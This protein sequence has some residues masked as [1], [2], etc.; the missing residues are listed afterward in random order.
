MILRGLTSTDTFTKK[1]SLYLLKR[2]I[3]VSINNPSIQPTTGWTKYFQI[4]ESNQK[5]MQSQWDTYLM[6]LET[7]AEFAVHLI[8]PIFTKITEL[9]PPK[10]IEPDQIKH[11]Y[12]YH[13]WLE[14]LLLQS[15]S[16]VNLG[17]ARMCLAAFY[18]FD[19]EKY[20]IFFSH[21]F[22]CSEIF[23]YFAGVKMYYKK[24]KMGDR[25]LKFYPDYLNRLDRE[26]AHSAVRALLTKLCTKQSRATICYIL[27]CLTLVRFDFGDEIIKCLDALYETHVVTMV[28]WLRQHV[29]RLIVHAMLS[30][31]DYKNCTSDAVWRFLSKFNKWCL[32]SHSFDLICNWLSC[33][34]SRMIHDLKMLMEEIYSN[35]EI[36]LMLCKRFTFMVPYLNASRDDLNDMLTLFH[37]NVKSIYTYVLFALLFTLYLATHFDVQD[38]EEILNFLK[39]TLRFDHESIAE[40]WHGLKPDY[41]KICADYIEKVVACLDGLRL[42]LITFLESLKSSP[43]S[44]I[45]AMN[46][47]VAVRACFELLNAISQNVSRWNSDQILE[48]LQAVTNTSIIRVATDSR[49]STISDQDSSQHYRALYIAQWKTAR[50]LLSQ[51]DQN[52]YDPIAML[53]SCLDALDAITLEDIN[54]VMD[55][56]KIVLPNVIRVDHD[57]DLQKVFE[58]ML[59]SLKSA[60]Y[61]NETLPY[62]SFAGILF[63]ESIILHDQQLVKTYFTKISNIYEIT[64]K[65][66]IPFAYELSRILS[67][68]KIIDFCVDCFTQMILF[69]NK[70]MEDFELEQCVIASHLQQDSNG[71]YPPLI[72]SERYIRALLLPSLQ[73]LIDS[74]QTSFVQKLIQ[75]VQDISVS[76]KF[77]QNVVMPNS[78]HHRHRIRIWTLL[79][80][81]IPCMNS[82][83]MLDVNKIYKVMLTDTLPSIRAYI[84]TLM[85]L[86]CI[87]FPSEMIP[88]L[89]KKLA[90][91]NSRAQNLAS[92]IT[93]AGQYILH[94]SDDAL[95]D[96][97]QTIGVSLL[98]YTNIHQYAVRSI[99]QLFMHAFI[100]R[101]DWIKIHKPIIYQSLCACPQYNENIL[102]GLDAFMS[103]SHSVVNWIYKFKNLINIGL[104]NAC[105]PNRLLNH[106]S[107][108]GDNIYM[109]TTPS[110][111]FEFARDVKLYYALYGCTNKS[112]E[113]KVNVPDY[114]G[115]PLRQPMKATNGL[116]YHYDLLPDTQVEWSQKIVP[117]AIVNE[118]QKQVNL[119]IGAAKVNQLI[120]GQIES[121]NVPNVQDGNFNFQKKITPWT[122]LEMSNQINPRIKQI[123][124]ERQS[125]IVMAT[126]VDKI[127]NLAGLS[128]T[129]EIFS[130]E[131]LVMSST[132]VTSHEM[133]KSIAVT[134]QNWL[135]MDEC[136]E[137]FV[138]PYLQTMRAN[139]YTIVGVE[140]TSDS[141]PIQNFVFPK[142][143]VIVLGKEKEG[144]PAETIRA[145][146]VCVEIPQYGMIRS[147]NV[148]VSA[149]IFMYEY[150]KQQL[151]DKK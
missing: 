62:T 129:C 49:P 30:T 95:V 42:K 1:R 37:Y 78:F 145:I 109:D 25:M 148:H 122:D 146:D 26:Q 21:D 128:R 74:N 33:D 24:E 48:M 113:T 6:L 23:D 127:P 60:K 110:E 4:S 142:K 45:Y 141:V 102:R 97:Y 118:Y 71:L 76:K 8:K 65:L 144:I 68:P 47:V 50:S 84:E 85:S 41:I 108:E 18:D 86:L 31:C 121:M 73:N 147:L 55:C 131:K 36:A 40:E 38:N 75:T 63:N 22:I 114:R 54:I 116:Q 100:Q 92:L 96:H 19:F 13:E 9:F 2:T 61:F 150:T 105:N 99:A 117:Q 125:L 32:S 39:Y 138:V 91:V 133:F 57:Y 10:H 132:K 104:W 149:S 130:A 98:E 82:S 52:G 28:V 3:D 81:C 143:C 34:S 51:C 107:D 137:E 139:G 59:T 103:N 35:T 120:L 112:Q 5:H 79:I 17:V 89:A 14:L 140:Q 44:R 29:S 70:N 94:C 126:Y 115:V 80:M 56:I 69:C 136:T 87:K 43:P 88:T 101:I 83:S 20:H 53:D 124:K 151:M 77:N 134:A 64:P 119:D 111:F 27:R 93:V 12:L 67:N 123:I 7:I 58:I 16:H 46:Y 72:R 15:F 11:L 90:D 135:P 106:V 66:S